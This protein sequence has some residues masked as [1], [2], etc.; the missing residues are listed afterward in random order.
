MIPSGSS[1]SNVDRSEISKFTLMADYW[2]DPAGPLKALHD[3]NRLRLNYIEE[4]SR[5][6]GK[7]VLDVGCGG[8]LLSE[9][10]AGLGARVTGIDMGEAALAAARAHLNSSGYAIDYRQATAEAF[11]DIRSGWFDAV[12]CLELLEH[13]PDPR[14]VIRACR[15]LVKPDGDVFFATL[16]RNPKSYLFAVLAGEYLLG[17]VPK[18]T[19]QY[20]KFIKPA[21]LRIWSRSAGL[22]CRDLTGLHYNPFT[23]RYTLGGNV[24]VNYLMHCRR[25]R[26]PRL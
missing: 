2:W 19:H 12:T 16:N 22:L 21:E 11:A 25:P 5:L 24:H 7:K 15:R 9:A 8:G 6:A 17:M 26:S 20:R 14:S 1:P 3:I 13:V 4:R 18:G 10:M 23:A